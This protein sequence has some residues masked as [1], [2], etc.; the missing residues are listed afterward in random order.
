MHDLKALVTCKEFCDSELYREKKKKEVVT[1]ILD[2]IFW[3]DFYMIIKVV[4]PLMRL[5]RI[6]DGDRKPS[7]G[8][9]FDGMLRARKAIKMI[10]CHKKRYYNV[11]THIIKRRW[12][13]HLKRSIHTAAYWLNPTFQYDREIFL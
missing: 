9:V 13:M 5:L 3:K 1:I 6:V 10:F 7:L 8:Y 12:D 2:D 11:Y 4:E